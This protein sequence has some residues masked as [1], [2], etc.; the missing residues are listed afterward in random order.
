M[1]D[2]QEV[3]KALEALNGNKGVTQL[4]VEMGWRDLS[5]LAE[6]IKL[7]LVPCNLGRPED[8]IHAYSIQ[9]R[10][11]WSNFPNR[12]EKARFNQRERH[13]QGLTILT[14]KCTDTFTI[15]YSFPITQVIPRS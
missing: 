5:P 15:Y 1:L 2:P 12:D 11:D 4:C 9:A 8:L 10:N 7:R 13:A 14:S 6:A 3:A